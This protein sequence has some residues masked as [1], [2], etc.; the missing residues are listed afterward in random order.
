MTRQLDRIEDTV[1]PAGPRVESV[2]DAGELAE[3]VRTYI[4]SRGVSPD[5]GNDVVHIE[6]QR[7]DNADIVRIAGV[8]DGRVA[9]TAMMLGSYGVAGVFLVHVAKSHRR[10]GIGAALTAAALR[11]GQDRGTE[12]GAL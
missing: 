5:M 4:A 7:A 3:R 1:Q 12:A 2:E 10:Q 8:M 9:G 11:T 6:S